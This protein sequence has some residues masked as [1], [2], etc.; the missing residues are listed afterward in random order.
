ME[1]R[2]RE[3]ERDGLLCRIQFSLLGEVLHTLL[4]CSNKSASPSRRGFIKSI[5]FVFGREHAQTCLH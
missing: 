1:K 4:A 3:K 2:E 5:Y